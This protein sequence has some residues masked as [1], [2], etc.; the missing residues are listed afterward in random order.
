MAGDAWRHFNM[1]ACV[2]FCQHVGKGQDARFYKFSSILPGLNKEN[3]QTA[4]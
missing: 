1:G 4:A 3:E 2:L